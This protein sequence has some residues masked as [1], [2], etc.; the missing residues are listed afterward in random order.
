MS[1][2]LRGEARRRRVVRWEWA[3]GRECWCKLGEIV[4]GG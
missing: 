2:G 4:S 1:A 3:G